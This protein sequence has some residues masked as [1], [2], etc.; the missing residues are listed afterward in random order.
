MPSMRLLKLNTDTAGATERTRTSTRLLSTGPKPV[1]STNF[2]TVAFP[3][4]SN[5]YSAILLSKIGQPAILL[6]AIRYGERPTQ[7]HAIFLRI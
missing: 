2:A 5:K 7:F 3:T 1:A 4:T 6:Q